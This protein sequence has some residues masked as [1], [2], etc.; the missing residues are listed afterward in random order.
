MHKAARFF[1]HAFSLDIQVRRAFGAMA[2]SAIESEIHRGEALHGG[3][4]RFVVEAA[5]SSPAVLANQSARE[6]AIDVFSYLRIW[7]TEHRNGVLIY[8]L[9]ADHAVE[10]IADRGIHARV[11]ATLWQSICEEMQQQFRQQHYHQGALAG[12]SQVNQLLATHFP[13]DSPKHNELCN[14]VMLL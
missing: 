14:K 4:V 12:V 6:R 13:T 1:R 11:G 3:E 2:L 5:L 9:W 8:L 7:D 10:I